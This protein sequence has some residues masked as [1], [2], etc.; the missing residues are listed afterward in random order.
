MYFTLN[1]LI[2]VFFLLHPLMDTSGEI[3]QSLLTLTSFQ[4]FENGN[5]FKIPTKIEK[6]DSVGRLSAS[7]EGSTKGLAVPLFAKME[8]VIPITCSFHVLVAC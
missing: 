7:F 4:D 8:F 2:F 5:S 3:H 1:L 6:L